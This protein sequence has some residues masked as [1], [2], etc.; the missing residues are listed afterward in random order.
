MDMGVDAAGYDEFSPC[1]DHAR[2]LEVE[3]LRRREDDDAA[4]TDADV[5]PLGCMR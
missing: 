3:R 5:A 2:G 4:A 1:V